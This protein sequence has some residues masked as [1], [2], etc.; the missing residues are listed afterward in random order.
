MHRRAGL[1]SFAFCLLAAN[2][3]AQGVTGAPYYAE[4]EHERVQTLADGTHITQKQ[5]GTKTWRDSQGRTRVERELPTPGQLTP[6]GQQPPAIVELNDPVQGVHYV[7]DMQRRIARRTTTPTRLPPLQ[8]PSQADAAGAT[9]RI[10]T[11][12]LAPQTRQVQ[13]PNPNAPQVAT[14]DLGM[15]V[16]EGVS[17]QGRRITTTFPVGAPADNSGPAWHLIWVARPRHEPPVARV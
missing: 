7:L 15:R 6:T 4:Q 9:G 2:A 3:P 16:I 8:R 17:A 14:E 13:P 12:R 5:P 11:A 10:A 1:A